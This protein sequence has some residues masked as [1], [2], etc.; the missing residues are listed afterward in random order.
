LS[1]TPAFI[2]AVECIVGKNVPRSEDDVIER[3]ERNEIFYLWNVVVGS[4]TK[5][6]RAHLRETTNGLRESAFD[7]LDTRD[8]CGTHRTEPNQQNT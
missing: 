4:F 2:A 7:R 3:R 6:D 8:K 5:T 1:R